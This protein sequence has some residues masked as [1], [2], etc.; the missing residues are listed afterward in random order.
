MSASAHHCLPWRTSYSSL[1]PVGL[2]LPCRDGALS[3][4]GEALERHELVLPNQM[5]L[6]NDAVHTLA[7]LTVAS[8]QTLA[9]P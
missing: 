8:D 5:A 2:V 4:E 3:V 6:V 9:A 1:S 7:D